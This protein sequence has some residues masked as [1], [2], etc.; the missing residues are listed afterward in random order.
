MLNFAVGP[1]MGDER[2]LSIGAQQV[3]YMRTQEFSDLMLE[4]EKMMLELVNAPSDSKAVFITGSGTASMEAVVMSVLSRDDQVLIVN[5]GSFGQRFVNLCRLHEIPYDEIRLESGAPLTADDLLKYENGDYTAFLINIHETSTGV[6]YDIDLVSDFCQRNGLLLVVDSIS[7]FLCDPFDMT[8]VK[9]NVML[10]G[11]QKALACPP[12]VSIIV[13]DEKAVGRVYDNPVKC[14]YLD[15]KDALDNQKRGQTPFTPAVQTLIQIHER[16]KQ[17][18]EE[19]GIEAE[20]SRVAALAEDFRKKIQDLPL[21]TAS[22]QMSN[23]CTPVTPLNENVSAYDI[24]LT[25]KDEYEIIV[26][27]NGGVL[28][29]KI[30]RVGHMGHLS[31]KDNDYLIHALKDMQKRGLL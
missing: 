12:G 6:L 25:L 30:F 20:I 2:I 5:G 14:M 8:M 11:S 24:F 17:I 31:M 15:L 10:T 7:S 28:K 29:D 9:A 1:V 23:A 21:R 4:N 27:P 3:P 18:K 26:C 19:G 22:P 16:L 13:M